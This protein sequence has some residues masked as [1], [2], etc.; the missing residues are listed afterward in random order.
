MPLGKTVGRTVVREY[1]HAID[2]KLERSWRGPD[3]AAHATIPNRQ[4]GF[5]ASGGPV[6]FQ[7]RTRNEIREINLKEAGS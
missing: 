6:V 3:Q 5:T 4:S 7:V 1:I 2:L